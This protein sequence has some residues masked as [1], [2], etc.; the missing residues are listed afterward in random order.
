MPRSRSYWIARGRWHRR[1]ADLALTHSRRAGGMA[2]ASKAQAVNTCRRPIAIEWGVGFM[3]SPAAVTMALP[4]TSR[5]PTSCMARQ[6]RSASCRGVRQTVD[7]WAIEGAEP[8]RSST[9]AA[10]RNRDAAAGRLLRTSMAGPRMSAVT[11]GMSALSTARRPSVARP[12]GQPSRRAFRPCVVSDENLRLHVPPR[13]P[14]TVGSAS[15]SKRSLCPSPER[16]IRKHGGRLRGR[17]VVL[18]IAGVNE[19]EPVFG[20]PG[21]R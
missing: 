17:G 5:A 1:Q 8:A 11:N 7:R 18:T 20:A 9:K 6:R 13:Q 2:N 10:A 19:P 21:F 14:I 4:S 15:A 12:E 16:K 3:V